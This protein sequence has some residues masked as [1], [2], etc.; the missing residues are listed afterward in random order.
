MTCVKYFSER[1]KRAG[2]GSIK[3]NEYVLDGVWSSDL[4][5]TP[6]SHRASVTPSPSGYNKVSQWCSEPWG[7]SHLRHLS[8]CAHTSTLPLFQLT[9]ALYFFVPFTPTP[10]PPPPSSLS[11]RLTFK[12]C[13]ILPS[14]YALYGLSWELIKSPPSLFSPNTPSYYFLPPFLLSLCF[15]ISCSVC[16]HTRTTTVTPQYINPEG[17]GRDSPEY[18]GVGVHLSVYARLRSLSIG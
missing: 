16:G 8:V 5:S 9:A 10:P 13:H 17:H 1:V 11:L 18:R 7:F 15:S 12:L 6:H 3:W 14:L 4:Y 2:E